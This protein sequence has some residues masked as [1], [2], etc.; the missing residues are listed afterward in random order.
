VEGF[1]NG[2]TLRGMRLSPNTTI[3]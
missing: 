3:Y 1:I 2:S